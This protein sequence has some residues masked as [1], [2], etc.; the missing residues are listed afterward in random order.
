MPQLEWSGASCLW[1][2]L[3]V[4]LCNLTY[5]QILFRYACLS[6][7][8]SSV[9]MPSPRCL[10]SLISHLRSLSPRFISLHLISS[11]LFLLFLSLKPSSLNLFSLPPSS[12]SVCP[13]PHL[14]S[15]P[16]PTPL[17]CPRP[18]IH[19]PLPPVLAQ[20]HL[21]PDP[22][23]SPP[24]TSLALVEC[25]PSHLAATDSDL[26]LRR[27]GGVFIVGSRP[28]L[29][30]QAPRRRI[31]H[32]QVSQTHAPS[33]ARTQAR[34][35]A[36]TRARAHT[37]TQA[38]RSRHTASSLP[39][40]HAHAPVRAAH[41][42]PRRRPSSPW[43]RRPPTVDMTLASHAPRPSSQSPPARSCAH[44]RAAAP[45]HPHPAARVRGV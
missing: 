6:A 42:P 24:P 16:P 14:R 32:P 37:H 35:H 33:H 1:R 8:L 22:A 19:L 4:S 39:P 30:P 38:R 15:S 17:L 34:T 41:A 9:F 43:S 11:L 25:S 44:P 31:P 36:S 28:A 29:L 18:P 3:T 10:S 12:R 5:H 27:S 40:P 21:Q 13:T 7:Y 45:A 23:L 26:A 2:S 20:T